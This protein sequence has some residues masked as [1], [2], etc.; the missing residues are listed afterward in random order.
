MPVQQRRG[1]GGSRS[2]D[3][4]QDPCGKRTFAAHLQRTE[5]CRRRAEKVPLLHMTCRKLQFSARVPRSHRRPV[6]SAGPPLHQRSRSSSLGALWWHRADAC[7]AAPTQLLCGNRHRRT[8]MHPRRP[9]RLCI[10]RKIFC[11]PS[12]KR[13]KRRRRPLRR[14]G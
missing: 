4:R 12:R 5:F 11:T 1:S 8:C 14:L 9:C 3:E 13:S 2:H 6:S 7:M 10:Y